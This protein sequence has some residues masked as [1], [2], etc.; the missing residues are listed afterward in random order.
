M[1]LRP[2]ILI[3]CLLV[4]VAASQL[5]EFAQQYRQRLAGAV[6][7]LN[8]IVDRFNADAAAEGLTQDEALQ[9]YRLS[10]DGFLRRQG[11][12]AAEVIAR[13]DRLV[14]QQRDLAG[15]PVLRIAPVVA[16]LDSELARRTLTDFEPAVPTTVEGAA[17]GGA[18]LVFGRLIASLIGL[19]PRR[20]RRVA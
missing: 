1:I 4:G 15:T 8:R 18:G 6:D 10:G 3:F 17:F 14:A 11:G 13:R 12:S 5:P 9:R 20:R 19:S 16:H 2:V 7:E